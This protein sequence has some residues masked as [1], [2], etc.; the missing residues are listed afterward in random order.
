MHEPVRKN[1]SEIFLIIDPGKFHTLKFIFE[2]YDNMMILSSINIRKGIIRVK[3]PYDYLRD[4][5]VLLASI[6]VNIKKITM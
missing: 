1:L 4:V 3:F 6:S 2:G 5:M